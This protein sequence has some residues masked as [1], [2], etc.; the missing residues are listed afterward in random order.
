M[1]EALVEELESVEVEGKR[2]LVARAAEAR[3]LVPDALRD[4]GAQ[5]DVVALYDTVAEPLDQAQLDGVAR[6]DRLTFTSS[7]TVRYFLDALQ[8]RRR[9]PSR[10]GRV[11]SIGPVT[12]D[13]ARE[14][15]LEVHREATEHDIDGLV[16]AV[17]EDSA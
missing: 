4:R 16:A 5:V 2:V 3:D 14:L 11:I 9:A 17:L 12:S 7:S 8:G 13:T 15:G 10:A 6:A 1:G